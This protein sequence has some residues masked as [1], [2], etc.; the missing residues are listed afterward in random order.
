M[1]PVLGSVNMV[2]RSLGAPCAEVDRML[3]DSIPYRYGL[4]AD[5]KLR[6]LPGP[7]L[8]ARLNVLWPRS[9]GLET[10]TV[11]GD[12]LRVRLPPGG[13]RDDACPMAEWETQERPDQ[14]LGEEM[15]RDR[16]L[17]YR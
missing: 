15:E 7:E 8:C 13:F 2:F 5:V 17:H 1:R 4:A 14:L 10:F 6:G 12:H 16:T 11:V 3:D 9:D